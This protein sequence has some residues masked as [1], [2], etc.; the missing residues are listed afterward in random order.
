M[1]TVTQLC[2]FSF[3]DT[4]SDIDR[5]RR[6]LCLLFTCGTEISVILSITDLHFPRIH[7]YVDKPT[8]QYRG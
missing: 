4:D 6:D 2:I 1:Y 5:V 8:D 7:L 3:T